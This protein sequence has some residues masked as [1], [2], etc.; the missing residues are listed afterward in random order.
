MT[1]CPIILN[2][3]T[4]GPPIYVPLHLVL[5]CPG[6]GFKGD[7]ARRLLK[8]LHGTPESLEPFDVDVLVIMEECTPARRQEAKET[9]AGMSLGGEG[10]A[11]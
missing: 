7:I 4:D 2:K 11:G 5:L 8:E 10:Q 9:A 1:P 3:S 6:M